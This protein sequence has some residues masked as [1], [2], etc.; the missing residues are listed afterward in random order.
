[1]AQGMRCG[2]NIKPGLFSEVRHHELDG[3]HGHALVVSILE[4][5][6]ASATEKP[7]AWLK[8]SSFAT[9]FWATA[10]SGTR[11]ACWPFAI[12]RTTSRVSRG[13]PCQATCD[14]H[15]AASSSPAGQCGRRRPPGNNRG[16][17]GALS[18]RRRPGAVSVQTRS[19]SSWG[20]SGHSGQG[21]PDPALGAW[22]LEDVSGSGSES[23][24]PFR[25]SPIG[26]PSS[27]VRATPVKERA[28]RSFA[29]AAWPSRVWRS[30][31]GNPLKHYRK[32][33]APLTGGDRTATLRHRWAR[34]ETEPLQR[35][36]GLGRWHGSSVVSVYRTL[37]GLASAKPDR[38]H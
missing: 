19:G 33:S 27:A 34:G 32:L 16:G 26:A 15:R 12:D 6:G 5:R 10:L 28:L 38:P 25:L 13:W 36:A 8:A 23:L 22:S 29:L 3:A 21:R 7:R 35:V 30:H 24:A 2:L 4:Q 37:A 9:A 18:N 17:P 14:T 1:M 11:R 20:T 31:S